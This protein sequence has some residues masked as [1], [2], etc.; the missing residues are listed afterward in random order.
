MNLHIPE[1]RHCALR[2][3]RYILKTEEYSMKTMQKTLCL[4]LTLAMLLACVPMKLSAA[5]EGETAAQPLVIRVEMSKSSYFVTS[6]AKATIYVQ[7]AGEETLNT[8]VVSAVSDKHLLAKGSESVFLIPTI[9]PGNTLI[10]TVEMVLDRSKAGVSFFERVLLF[11]AQLFRSYDEMTALSPTTGAAVTQTEA[12]RHGSVN[13]TLTVEAQYS[14]GG[15]GETPAVTYRD[16]YLVAPLASGSFTATLENQ[17]FNVPITIYYDRD[18]LAVSGNIVKLLLNLDADLKLPAALEN[19]G[20]CKLVVTDKTTSP[21]FYLVFA[22]RY[23]D[24]TDLEIDKDEDGDPITLKDNAEDF[25]AMI[26]AMLSDL[27]KYAH[28]DGMEYA[29]YQVGNGFVVESY[30]N[31]ESNTMTSYYFT[32][33]GLAKIEVVDMETG[34]AVETILIELHAGITDEN[35]FKVTGIKHSADELA[36]LFAGIA[37]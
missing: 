4:L 13:A 30:K 19:L 17:E 24:L 9:V 5:A 32:A 22:A 11:F 36:Q 31:T 18:R 14:I 33:K 1:G 29:G 2:Q 23:Y 20:T 3:R 21:R 8:L 37:G 26:D 15:N 28:G 16:K 27:Q 34:K 10:Y 35:A 25:F 6:K 7:N 12:F